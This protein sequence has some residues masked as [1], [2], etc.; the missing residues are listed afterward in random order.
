MDEKTKHQLKIERVR[1]MKNPT[2]L[3]NSKDLE[4]FTKQLETYE[5]I[6]IV[7]DEYIE[8]GNMIIYDDVKQSSTVEEV[9]SVIKKH[10]L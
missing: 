6:P 9:I 7:I 4:P 5:G 1:K 2:V 10:L 3:M 8:E